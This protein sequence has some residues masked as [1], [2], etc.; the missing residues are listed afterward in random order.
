MYIYRNKLDFNIKDDNKINVIIVQTKESSLATMVDNLSRKDNIMLL[1][2]TVDKYKLVDQTILVLFPELAFSSSDFYIIDNLLREVK[3]DIIFISGFG[4]CNG[5]QISKI[6]RLE[7]VVLAIDDSEKISEDLKYNYGVA[8][9]KKGKDIEAFI[10]LKNFADQNLEITQVN[11]LYLSKSITRIDTTD[12]ILFFLICADLINTTKSNPVDRISISLKNNP[13][14]KNQQVIVTALL[15]TKKPKHLLWEKNFKRLLKEVKYKIVFLLANQSIESDELTF[16]LTGYLTNFN[17]FNSRNKKNIK[18]NEFFTQTTNP[19]L[20][21]GTIKCSNFT[22]LDQLKR[23]SLTSEKGIHRLKIKRN[24]THISK[25]N[26]YIKIVSDRN[27]LQKDELSVI[28]GNTIIASSHQ[29]LNNPPGSTNLN[30]LDFIFRNNRNIQLLPDNTPTLI[31]FPELCF[32][33]GD[34]K[35]ILKIIIEQK[36]PLLFFAGVGLCDR[37]EID[38]VAADYNII[39]FTSIKDSMHDKKYLYDTCVFINYSPGKFFEKYLIFNNAKYDIDFFKFAKLPFPMPMVRV[40]YNDVSIYLVIGDDLDGGKLNLLNN[41][42]SNIKSNVHDKILI[43]NICCH[44]F[45]SFIDK[46]KS[47]EKITNDPSVVLYILESL[48]GDI[49]EKNNVLLSGAYTN[50]SNIDVIFN[51]EMQTVK[52]KIDNH[53]IAFRDRLYLPGISSGI[54]RWEQSVQKGRGTYVPAQRYIYKGDRFKKIYGNKDAQELYNYFIRN[55]DRII[56]KAPDYIKDSYIKELYKLIESFELK[57]FEN[58]FRDPILWPKIITG[59]EKEREAEVRTEEIDLYE[60]MIDIIIPAI[61]SIKILV[62]ASFSSHKKL[63]GQLF[64]EEKNL[65]VLIW[66]SP[67]YSTTFVLNLLQQT[68]S[69]SGSYYPLLVLAA[70]ND[71]QTLPG[72][73]QII[74]DRLTDYTL[75]Y[76][77]R[78]TKNIRSIIRPRHRY[79][80]FMNLNYFI[81][82]LYSFNDINDMF[83]FLENNLETLTKTQEIHNRRL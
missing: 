76:S 35:Y 18:Y 9:F 13:P 66:K 16:N 34:L 19:G 10:F 63:Y 1:R 58:M 20:L 25:K 31:A 8:W 12:S 56:K 47:I 64:V 29:I 78:I 75:D 30:M 62:N 53:Y 55:K 33:I 67:W 23:L 5:D 2:S 50:T 22:V 52:Y 72:A 70:G 14:N 4:F 73:F 39:P 42:L 15:N 38:G 59:I 48:S 41:L 37:K 36:K 7:H 79:I 54:L 46:N 74:P 49:P 51:K 71:N 61:L 60:D 81:K 83:V 3:S 69:M 17:S 11:D 27:L 26:G 21:V 68:S 80:D 44:R 65:D 57:I 40:D 43:L 32:G 82:H 77:S 45:V 24:K 6:S 28:F